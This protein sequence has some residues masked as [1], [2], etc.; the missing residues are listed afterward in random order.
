ME[1]R[2][3]F[4]DKKLSDLVKKIIVYLAVA[5]IG[6]LVGR[7]SVMEICAP[8]GASV[9]CAT[10]IAKKEWYFSIS[11]GVIL[12]SLLLIE[13]QM[14]YYMCVNGLTALL[15]IM[16]QYVKIPKRIAI[17][18]SLII[19]YT[20][21]YFIILPTVPFNVIT[22]IFE[23]LFCCGFV[24]VF[25]SAITSIAERKNMMFKEEEII[26]L[27]FVAIIVVLGFGGISIANIYVSNVVAIFFAMLFAYLGGIGLG[28]ACGVALGAAAAL[29]MSNSLFFIG[30]LGLC[31]IGG[32]VLRRLNRFAMV[33]GFI[34]INATLTF[35]FTKGSEL[36]IPLM[37]SLA[38]GAIFLFI[39]KRILDITGRFIDTN[40]SR[41]YIAEQQWSNL[42]KSTTSRLRDVGEI[43]RAIGT[44]F[45]GG[46]EEEDNSNE[47]IAK[48]AQ[49][50]CSK[51]FSKRNCWDTEF[52]Q[53]FAVFDDLFDNYDNNTA[54]TLPNDFAKKCH[55]QDIITKNVGKVYE[56]Y[57]LSES[58]RSKV[59]ATKQLTGQQLLEVANLIEALSSDMEKN[60]LSTTTAQRKYRV[61]TGN[62]ERGFNGVSG[63]VFSFKTLPD[64][65]FLTLLCDGMGHG[66]EANKAAQ[67]SISLI[68]SFYSAGF[69]KK[70]ILSTINRLMV[71]NN[72]SDMY[73]TVDMCVVDLTDGIAEF[74]KIG[75]E[76][77]FLLRNRELM[78]M[79]APAL[80]MGIV[81][82]IRPAMFRKQLQEGDFVIML[83]DGVGDIIGEEIAPWL[84]NIVDS[85]SEDPDALAQDI[86]EHARRNGEV[87]DD[88][89]VIVLRI[90]KI[91]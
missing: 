38:A 16:P 82:D 32:G 62:A 78:C 24:F 28:C 81:D 46:E 52:A 63:D 42:R 6:V 13:Q 18:A 41:E 72:T 33:I 70:T 22:R 31:A 44:M 65:R 87:N 39:P 55:R 58:W 85:P 3:F 43:F 80:P 1:A 88:M 20:S 84:L 91:E 17:F 56:E 25:E 57:M 36:I 73:T 23:L 2:V 35:V 10:A 86:L 76:R 40:I 79:S 9:I 4:A 83:T 89:T 74:T 71:L 68:R 19:A 37:D 61:L 30:N 34:L 12:G 66:E 8:F 7:V 50:S 5:G 29:S 64:G 51:C 48:L 27:C 49:V 75:A 77:S 11:I 15:C 26:A 67:D 53:T 60:I 45:S 54:V 90:E 14:W 47:A 69:G 21:A 59:N